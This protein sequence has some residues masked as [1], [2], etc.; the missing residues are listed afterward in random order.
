MTFI[1]N[2]TN[3]S[4]KLDTLLEVT[5]EFKETG[6]LFIGRSSDNCEN[7]FVIIDHIKN[8]SLNIIYEPYFYLSAIFLL[9]LTFLQNCLIEDC[10]IHDKL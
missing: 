5:A 4:R 8:L 10:I 9:L 7:F 6:L 2:I 1:E 3:F